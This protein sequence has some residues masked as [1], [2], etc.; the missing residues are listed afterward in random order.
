[1]DNELELMQRL[2]EQK[3]DELHVLYNVSKVVGGSLK[4]AELHSEL[5]R[6]LKKAMGLSAMTIYATVPDS[7]ALSLSFTT[8]KAKN[9][10]EN[11]PSGE[12]APYIAA[13]TARPFFVKDRSTFQ[14]FLHMPGEGR[15]NGASVI[16][17]PLKPRA[18]TAGVL[19]VERRTPRFTSD[20]VDL[21][22]MVGLLVAI[23]LEKAALFEKTEGLSLRDGLTGL[24]NHRT[25]MDRLREEHARMKRTRRPLS[26]VMMDIDHFK[27][28]NDTFGHKEGDRV[29]TEISALLTEQVRTAPTDVLARYGGEEFGLL[30]AETP[31]QDALNIA[32]RLRA[33]VSAHPF[34]LVRDHPGEHVTISVG[35]SSQAR[36][37]LTDTDLV[38]TA[39]NA[40]YYSKRGG[41]DKTSY[42]W[43]GGCFFYGEVSPAS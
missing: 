3:V 35:V 5:W 14:G 13:R 18:G 11:I 7:G 19:V 2:L 31:L 39:D 6:T 34:G 8:L 20:D 9:A 41:R 10:K 17:T 32:E 23:G 43:D 38:I 24:F 22:A 1:M 15:R 12:G 21:M 30:L 25:L 40:L 27:H 4:Q 33:V 42:A 29:L 36:E 16:A 28:V 26:F 37:D